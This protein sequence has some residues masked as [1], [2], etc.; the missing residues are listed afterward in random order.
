MHNFTD[1]AKKGGSFLIQALFEDNQVIDFCCLVNKAP[2]LRTV[3]YWLHSSIDWFSISFRL[4]NR[5][6]EPVEN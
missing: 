3:G 5:R 2:L 4:K 1:I 6:I